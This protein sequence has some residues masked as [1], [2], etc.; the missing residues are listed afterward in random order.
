MVE[1]AGLFKADAISK[2]V[3][4]LD[5][6]LMEWIKLIEQLD[7]YGKAALHSVPDEFIGKK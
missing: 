6:F 5:K 2:G 1:L 4:A 7:K 3:N